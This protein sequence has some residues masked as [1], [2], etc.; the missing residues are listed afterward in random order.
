[1]PGMTFR[2]R[3]FASP[4]MHLIVS[5]LGIGTLVALT[6]Q[7]LRLLQWLMSR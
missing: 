2:A 7:V 1:M 5:V 6:D 3:W 4:Q